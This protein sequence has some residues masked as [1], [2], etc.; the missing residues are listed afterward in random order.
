MAE[1]VDAVVFDL[2]DTLIDW[3]GSW[4]AC[5]AGFAEPSV[6]EA[7]DH[8]L[9]CHSW[10]VRPGSVGQVWHRN[11]WQVFEH[12]HDL[13]PRALS[14]LTPD[15]V[16]DLIRLFEERLVVDFFEEVIPTLD[17]LGRHHRLAV[18]SNNIHLPAEAARL[19]LGRWFEA[20]LVAHPVAKPHPD[21]FLSACAQLGTDPA[22]TWYVGDSVRADA[23]GAAGAGLV[24]VWVDR[25]GDPWPDRPSGV[26]RVADLAGLVSLLS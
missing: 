5:V 26:H 9:R 11:T 12:R 24:P 21:A 6:V 2:D 4:T 14:D 20:C 22:A 8:H 16:A 3:W 19:D 7:L 23:L 25:F 1:R 15:E 18:L 13:W 17:H 10:E